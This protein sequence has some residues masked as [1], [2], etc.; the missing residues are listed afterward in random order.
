M[1]PIRM[2]RRIGSLL[3]GLGLLAGTTLASAVIVHATIP[4][5]NVISACYSRSGGALRVIDDSVTKCKA[6]E[7]SLAWNVQGV[8]GP[9]G[10]QG[11]TGSAG[12]AGPTGPTGPEGD[13]GPAGPAGPAGPGWS[14]YH[15]AAP[16]TIPAGT[17]STFDRSCNAG[18]TAL[19]AT[20]DS[21]YD[22]GVAGAPEVANRIAAGTFRF[23][24]GNS[25]TAP[26]TFNSFGVVCADTTP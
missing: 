6:G 26:R 10:P 4:S 17:I 8:Q 22:G 25:G 23:R 11:L 7:T 18:D 15:A 24:Y 14:I 19:S 21:G 5:N 9:A 16:Q 20:W 3:T 1:Q 13:P 12:P 2:R